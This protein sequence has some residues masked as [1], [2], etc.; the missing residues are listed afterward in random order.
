MHGG[1]A[2]PFLSVPHGFFGKE[3]GIVGKDW[4]HK[5]LACAGLQ[6]ALRIPPLV[7]PRQNHTSN[8]IVL[9]TEASFSEMNHPADALVTRHSHVA[10][11]ILT[12]DCAPVLLHDTHGIIG[13]VHAGWKGAIS[14]ILEHT[15][16]AMETLGATMSTL[17]AVMG[18]MVHVLNYEVGPE[19]P[20][21][22]ARSTPFETDP[23]FLMQHEKLY[24][25]LPKYVA[26]RLKPKVGRVFDVGI[27]TFG[28]AFFSRRFALSIGEMSWGSSLSCIALT[29]LEGEKNET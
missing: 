3:L 23:F 28:S 22:V 6:K 9:E 10:L 25:N 4:E 20:E 7:L 5:S 19:F 8:V 21:V 14:G 11:G 2:C 12:A 29:T 18:P 15:I 17:T 13:I 26:H 16:Q 1:I 24:F 27:N